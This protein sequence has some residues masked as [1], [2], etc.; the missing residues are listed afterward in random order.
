MTL[1]HSHEYFVEK[2]SHLGRQVR[3]ALLAARQKQGDLAGVAKLTAADTIYRIDTEVEPIIE[4]FCEH[5]GREVP[6]VLIAEG[7]AGEDGT[8]GHAV[9]PRGST[10][11]AAQIRVL[12]D[13]IDG[14]R[15]IM[16]DKRSAWFLSGVAPNHGDATRLSDI[17]VAVQV[18]LPTSK[19]SVSDVLWAA[20][21]QGAQGRR[22]VLRGLE[23]V[24][25]QPLAL[26]PSRADTIAHGF[27]AIANFF[28]G[29]KELASR[30]MERIVD[31]CLPPEG[32]DASGL[33]IVFD[34]QYISTGGQFYELIMGHDR[35]IADLRPFFYRVRGVP[36]SLCVHPYDVATALIATEA[37]VQLTDGLGGPL[38]GPLDITT[39][40]AFAA[41]ANATL[42]AQIEPVVVRELTAWLR[43]RPAL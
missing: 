16:Y 38:D 37:G 14:T 20:R 19:Q 1:P 18:E 39:P 28:P 13:P 17:E 3:N 31:A 43:E 36:V 32:R 23:T 15:G 11:A 22:E 25:S 35:F 4:E 2:L 24:D 6:L 29:T 5:W 9:F 8:E 12:V 27:A 41:Y 21:G 10:A 33:G 26:R 34:D 7:I 30:L 40:L 42:R